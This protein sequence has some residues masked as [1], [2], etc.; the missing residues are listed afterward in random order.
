MLDERYIEMIDDYLE[1][2]LDQNEKEKLEAELKESQEL[3]DLMALIKLTRESIKMSGQKEMIQQIHEEF[4]KEPKDEIHTDNPKSFR[5]SPWWLGV[6]ASISL[7]I[8]IGNFWVKTQTEN[9]FNEKYVAYNLPTMRSTEGIENELTMLFKDADYEAVIEIV[10]LGS[11][12]L[13]E[14]FLAG[15]SHFE[16]ENYEGSVRF[17]KKIQEINETKAASSLVFQDE[18]DYYLFLAY[19]KMANLKDADQYYSRITTD[20]NHTYHKNINLKDKL[21]FN[22]LKLKN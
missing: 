10:D 5:I 17:L 22:I 14:L 20:K 6:A 18:S 4:I 15:I 16:M 8:L 7:F 11:E 2:I 21:K 1:G 3:R 9:V 19:L 12:N 13:N